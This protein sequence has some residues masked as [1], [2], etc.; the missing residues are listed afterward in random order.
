MGL[1]EVCVV[2]QFHSQ[3]KK[4]YDFLCEE[5]AKMK[6]DELALTTNVTLLKQDLAKHKVNTFYSSL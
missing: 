2:F 1:C 6:T 5:D 3:W 4:L